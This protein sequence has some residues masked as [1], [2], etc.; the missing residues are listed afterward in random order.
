[1]TIHTWKKHSSPVITAMKTIKTFLSYPYTHIKRVKL[2]RLTLPK[3]WQG[4]RGTGTFLPSYEQ[5]K[6]VR[7]VHEEI[8][9]FAIK[10]SIYLIYD[11][12][13]VLLNMYLNEVKTCPHKDFYPNVHSSFM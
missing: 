13:V 8:W 3:C 10:L 1:M 6:V 12:A 5:S 2:K 9:H 11:P 7:P 4:R